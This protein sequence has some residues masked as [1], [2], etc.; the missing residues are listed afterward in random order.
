MRKVICTK[1]MMIV[2]WALTLAVAAAAQNAPKPPEVPKPLI[3]LKVDVVINEYS[4]AKKI[5]SL[6]YAIYV[7]SNQRGNSTLRMGLRVPIVVGVAS[8]NS[9]TASNLIRYQDVGTDID[10]GV[11][12]V[13]NAAYEVSLSV[14]WS[15]LYSPSTSSAENGSEVQV[16]HDSYHPIFSNFSTNL[17]LLMRDGQTIESTMATD[18]ISGH[19]I[20]VDTTLHVM[21]GE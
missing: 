21:K 14:Q 7:H 6:P 2:A 20:K 5:T 4:G 15:S 9:K 10:C 13:D 12:S 17:K 18:P 11:T 3:P 16:S 1:M 19:V 8:L